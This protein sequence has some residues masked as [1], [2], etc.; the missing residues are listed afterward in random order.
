MPSVKETIAKILRDARGPL[1]LVQITD[2][3]NRQDPA[4]G[5]HSYDEVRGQLEQMDEVHVS[6]GTYCLKG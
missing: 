6:R 1:T 4:G 5:P 2:A 3:L